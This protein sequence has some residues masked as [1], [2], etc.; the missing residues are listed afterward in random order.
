MGAPMT[1]SQRRLAPI[2]LAC[3]MQFFF[4]QMWLGT[5]PPSTSAQQAAADA[6]AQPALIPYI[7]THA[8]FDAKILSEPNDEVAVALREMARENATKL[9]FMP[10]PYL[11]D[12]PKRFDYEAFLAAVR[13]HPDKLAFQ[14][15]GGSLNP[16]IQE[17]V[18]NRSADPEVL[19]TFKE[20]AERILRDGA[21]GFGEVTAE[22]L[23]FLPAQA[24]EYAPPDHPLFLL[25]ADIA[26][27]HNVPIDLHMEA[28]PQAMSLP[29]DL[30]SPPNPAHLH[31]NIAAFEI[32]LG[33][34][35]RAKIIWA[36]AGSD[37]TGYR[38]PDL[39]GRL[40]HA[41]SNLF[42]ELKTDPLTLGKNPLFAGGKIKPEW[43]KLLQ[44]YPERFVIGTDQ[45]Y[46]SGRPMEGPQRW[47]M[48]VRLL[49]QLPPGLR[50][51]ISSENAVR[52]FNIPQTK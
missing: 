5:R 26:A 19:R 4:G 46:A 39:C 40:L 11:P 18:Q 16:M 52:I 9:I 15:G 12:D 20:R 38:T 48:A 25:L 47:K 36:H 34:N 51:K 8:H 23:S 2:S 1:R 31:E 45:H 6:P 24:Y 28:V 27:E 21:I 3:A 44:D 32:L 33:H 22:H 41:H 7:D 43:L 17:S 30:K 35:P 37:S 13:K 14:G 10:G 50:R 42:M 49:D 29:L